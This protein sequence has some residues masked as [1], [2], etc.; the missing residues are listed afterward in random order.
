LETNPQQANE[1]G[2][3]HNWQGEEKK[4]LFLADWQSG[5]KK[6]VATKHTVY[7]GGTHAPGD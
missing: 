1:A 5:K 4:Q 7:R 3:Q 6:N 2:F